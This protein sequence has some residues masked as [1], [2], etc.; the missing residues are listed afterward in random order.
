[1]G[2][3]T[4]DADRLIGELHRIYTWYNESPERPF[5][6]DMAPVLKELPVRL[7]PIEEWAR[8]QTLPEAA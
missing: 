3:R 7:T 6:V 4:L 8:Q 5:Q 2:S 1:M